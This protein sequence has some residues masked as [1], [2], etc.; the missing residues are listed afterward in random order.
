[1][2]NFRIAQTC[3]STVETP[4]YFLFEVFFASY[5]LSKIVPSGTFCSFSQRS[6]KKL[7]D[8]ILEADQAFIST[9][10]IWRQPFRSS[11]G[12]SALINGY[13]TRHAWA[14]RNTYLLK[15]FP[16]VSN[17]IS[18][19]HFRPQLRGVTP[20]FTSSF[21]TSSCGESKRSP[22]TPGPRE[23]LPGNHGHLR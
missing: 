3:L 18:R 4:K 14:L 13:T 9:S 17:T 22:Q 19:Y 10:D 7:T 6:R 16:S 1:M 20:S 12:L 2:Q 5:P 15:R 23:R 11:L 21:D 8:V